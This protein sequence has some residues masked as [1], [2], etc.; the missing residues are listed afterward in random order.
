MRGATYEATAGRA[1]G[2]D[3]G[4]I[5]ARI[6]FEDRGHATPCWI[7]QLG[8]NEKGYGSCH[9]YGLHTRA[10]RIAY[11]AFVGPI[12]PGHEIDHL[13]YVP[14][15]AN[16]DHLEAVTPEVNRERQTLDG[17][18]RTTPRRGEKASGAKLKTADIE[19]IRKDQRM[20]IAIAADYGVDRSTISNIKRR[21]SWAHL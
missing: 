7:W 8:L 14:A 9:R 10:H 20:Q 3:Q 5:L 17:R 16:P 13:C 6:A 12:P 15:C 2:G 11:E 19:Q 4:Y 1:N 18:V 21:R